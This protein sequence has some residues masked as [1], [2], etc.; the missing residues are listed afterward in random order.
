MRFIL[1]FACSVVIIY[2][3]FIGRAAVNTSET[4][5]QGLDDV[6]RLNRRAQEAL[7]DKVEITDYSA[8]SEMK[9]GT[10]TWDAAL[11]RAMSEHA[12]VVFPRGDYQFAETILVG[13]N[14]RLEV[15]VDATVGHAPAFDGLL[16]RNAPG[17]KNIQISGGVWYDHPRDRVKYGNYRAS[18]GDNSQMFRFLG[19]EGV[20]FRDLVVSN[21]PTFSFQAGGITNLLVENI[22]IIRGG[23]DGIHLNGWVKNAVVRNVRGNMGDDIVALNAWD[24]PKSTECYG[25]SEDVLIDDVQGSY[26]AIRLLPGRMRALDCSIQRVV[27]RNCSGLCGVKMAF[28][29][30]RSPFQTMGHLSDI[31][32]QDLSLD[33]VHSYTE[34]PKLARKPGG[35]GHFAAFEF[36]SDAERVNF[37]N[38]TV[39]FHAD[40]FPSGHFLLVG[41]WWWE[42]R[43]T[44]VVKHVVV[45]RFKATGVVPDELCHE[46]VFDSAALGRDFTGRGRFEDVIFVGGV[47]ADGCE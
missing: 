24:W 47:C 15:N 17:A 38:V 25:P 10:R 21:A 41:P 2:W 36:G 6:C 23:A 46:T 11:R 3:A 14:C 27:V 34:D 12:V 26:G 20:T 16:V 39:N 37:R 28:Q 29:G 40:R 13:S 42:G 33:L 5:I 8:L 7:V 32:F 30:V 35:R 45:D 4:I 1:S 19:C 22:R 18:V 9:G 43:I 44:P 31:Y